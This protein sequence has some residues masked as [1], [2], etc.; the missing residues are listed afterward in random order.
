MKNI[1]ASVKAR[2]LN[3]A[4]LEGRDYSRLLVL[5]TST[6]PAQ[7]ACL[8]LQDRVFLLC[9]ENYLFSKKS[10]HSPNVW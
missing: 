5:E 3:L 4:R 2:L 9:S 6:A 10:N 7:P 8:F 1:A